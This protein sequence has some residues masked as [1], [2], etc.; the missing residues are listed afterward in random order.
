MGVVIRDNNNNGLVI[1]SL[2]QQLLLA[3]QAVDIEALAAIRALEFA[4]EVSINRAIVEGDSEVVVKALAMEEF[5][6]ASHGQLLKDSVYFSSQ[7]SKL[8]YYH[9][10]REGNKIAHK[11]TRL[12]TN[13][14]NCAM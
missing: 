4:L 7:Y 12:A 6:L 13:T 14:V 1:T 9:A 10:K 2:I 11:L 8:L 5:S 3:Y